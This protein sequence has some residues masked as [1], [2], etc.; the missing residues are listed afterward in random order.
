M[1]IERNQDLTYERVAEVFRCDA[2]TGVLERKLKSGR[3]RACG[4]K[5]NHSSGYSHLKIDG[6]NYLAHR[7]IWLLTYR[8]WPKFIDHID[9]NPMNNR[10]DNLRSAT[11]Q[12]NNHNRGMNKN[13][14]SGY[15]GVSFF[16]RDNKWMAYIRVNS[17]QTFLGYFDTPEEAFTA[18]MLA[19]IKYHPTSP[20][21]QQYLRELT[22]AG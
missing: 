10:I 16:K 12:E 13:S 22:L 21:A 2:E 6:K 9:K 7:L 3:W 8:T 15:P 18:Y 17:K 19:K 11:R 1:N 14:S 4:D 20:I 5:H